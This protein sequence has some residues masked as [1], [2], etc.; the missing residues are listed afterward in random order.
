MQ[1]KS[2]TTSMVLIRRCF[3]MGT[4][5]RRRPQ[6]LAQKLLTIRRAFK[7]SQNS[8]LRRLELSD[9]LSQ[10]DVSA[11]ERGTREPP[12]EILLKYAQAAGVWIDVLVDD[13]LDL[14]EKLPASPKSEGIRRKK[15]SRSKKN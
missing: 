8:L 15:S 2:G 5:A 4:F 9:E 6:K 12:L 11:F 7:E 1:A 3:L 10:S 13:E 14:P